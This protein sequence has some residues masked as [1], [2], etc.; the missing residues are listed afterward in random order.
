[1]A[2]LSTFAEVFFAGDGHDVFEFSQRHALIVRLFG[3]T[4]ITGLTHPV[5]CRSQNAFL[6]I[7]CIEL[8]FYPYLSDTSSYQIH[9]AQNIIHDGV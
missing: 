2:G 5:E 4:M 9:S 6:P 1:M 7:S 3:V 8:A